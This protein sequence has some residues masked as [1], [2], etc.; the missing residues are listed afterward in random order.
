MTESMKY[1]GYIRVS[2][3]QQKEDEAHI[4][5]QDQIE[6]WANDQGHDLDLFKDIAVSGQSDSRESYQ[7]MM[8]SLEEYDGVVVRELS[9]FGRS[10]KRVLNDIEKLEEH[11]VVFTSLN[12]DVDTSTAQGKLLFQIIGAFNEFWANL[13]RERSLE[14]IEKRRAE[15][16]DIGRPE[17]L[18]P[19]KIQDLINDR[20]KGISYSAL[21]KIYQEYTDDG[22]LDRSTVKRYCDRYIEEEDEE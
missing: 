22:N 8:N 15:G 1:A 6:D 7:E 3:T 20:E 4:R 5:Q 11:D 21:S 12:D 13:A 17:K 19:E 2:T 14:M 10:L 16:K 18:P 9:R